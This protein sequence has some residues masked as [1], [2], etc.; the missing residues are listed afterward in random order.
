MPKVTVED[1]AEYLE[2]F[3]GDST[4]GW[5][6]CC[7]HPD[8]KPSLRLLSSGY[9][10]MSCGE[11]GSL[12]WLLQK[13]SGRIVIREKTYNP[14][15]F[16]WRNWQE[17]FGSIK[18]IAKVAHNNL[19]HNPD[20]AHYL[21]Q[22]KIN[23][24][25]NPGFFGYMDGFYI[26]PIFDEYKEIQGLIS[27]A[28]PTIQTKNNRYSVT[29]ECPTKIYVP[30]WKKVS[31]DDSLY[32]CFGTLDAWTLHIAGYAGMTGLTGQKFEPSYLDSFRKRIYI[33]PDRHEEKSA[34]ELQASLGWR[35]CPL[36]LDWPTDCKD[37]QDVHIL[38]G[39]DTVSELIDKAK[40]RYDYED[41]K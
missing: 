38:Y 2:Q 3:H 39:V 34:I 4:H 33:I 14:A 18:E 9:R 26:F 13:V 29:K 10:C 15:S 25:I 41:Y 27:R 7:F 17:K 23:S 1:V 19:V 40:R 35:G 6:L 22:R 24:Q 36:Y 21:V 37:L 8:T 12:E 32:L 28:S 11:H 16:I 20:S 31:N 30:S 5:A